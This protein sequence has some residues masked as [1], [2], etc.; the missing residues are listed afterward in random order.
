[1]NAV[2]LDADTLDALE[3]A[4]R[5]GVTHPTDVIRLVE[6]VRW[7]RAWV[8]F[9]VAVTGYDPRTDPGVYV[10]PSPSDARAVCQACGSSVVCHT[11]GT[12]CDGLA[13]TVEAVDATSTDGVYGCRV[14]YTIVSDDELEVTDDA[15]VPPVI[16]NEGP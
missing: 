15:D 6:E 1:M 11:G 9:T 3:A 4:A 13:G 5:A 16:V 7:Y 14:G 10:G 8:D 2:R 12:W